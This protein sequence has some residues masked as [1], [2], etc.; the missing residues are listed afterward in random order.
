MLNRMLLGLF[1]LLAGSSHAGDIPSASAPQ[2][3][4]SIIKTSK[5]TVPEALIYPGGSLSNKVDSNFVAFLIKHGDQHLLFD[6]GL[7]SKV[8]E[9]YAQ[10]MRLWQQP[11]FR[12]DAPVI[13][14]VCRGVEGVAAMP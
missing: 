11:F 2:V 6:T 4:L 9:E 1:A 7:S 3:G 8:D 5:V 10:D 13:S 14:A 12:Y